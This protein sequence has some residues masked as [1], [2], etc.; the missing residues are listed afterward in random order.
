VWGLLRQ[1]D[2]G[3]LRVAWANYQIIQS[4]S[5]N[6]DLEYPSPFKEML[7]VLSIFSLDFLSLDCLFENSDHL[8]SVYVWSA[9][10]IILAALI[11]LV[12]VAEG[13]FS[14]KVGNP[15]PKTATLTYRLLLLC[16]LV[17]PPVTFKQLQAL[18]CVTVAG[19]SFLRID[20]SIDCH[21]RLGGEN[22]KEKRSH[23]HPSKH[24]KQAVHSVQKGHFLSY[25]CFYGV[26]TNPSKKIIYFIK[27][28]S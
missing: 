11:V 25:F 27:F 3:D 23:W 21:S 24:P 20:T 4:S 22:M 13:A 6:L 14:W 15:C 9:V 5:W 10:P 1:L 17:L 28:Q 16:Y 19:G 2:S 26:K 8:L 18:D 7:N 12:H